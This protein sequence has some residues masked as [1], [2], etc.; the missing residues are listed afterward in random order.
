MQVLFTKCPL[1]SKYNYAAPSI[2]FYLSCFPHESQVLFFQRREHGL[3]LQK[4]TD[5]SQRDVSFNDLHTALT[6]AD[7][8]L[9]YF[10]RI[11]NTRELP[12]RLI[13][14]PMAGSTFHTVRPKPFLDFFFLILFF[15][16]FFWPNM[17]LPL[18]MNLLSW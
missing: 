4:Q 9:I 14:R 16:C 1:F 12:T 15:F 13:S 8:L 6:P 3:V 18:S 10:R 5:I 7:V 2:K 11:P 17:F